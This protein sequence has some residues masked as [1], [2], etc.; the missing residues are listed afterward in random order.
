MENKLIQFGA[1]NIGRSFIGQ[2]FARNGYE[3]V[4]IDIDDTV[5]EEM[6]RRHNYRL[7]IKRNETE[8]ETVLVENVRAVHGS[9]FEAVASEIS[10]AAYIGSSVGQTAL[11]HIIPVIAKGLE[12]RRK[13][14]EVMDCID[15]II[16]ENIRNGAEFFR[17]GLKTH[18]PAEF[19]L[20]EKVGFVETS[21]G[22][23]VPIMRKEDR[24]IDP[25]WVFAEEY[26][27]LIVD[28]KGF[29]SS[30]PDLPGLKPVDNI[31]AYVDRKLFIHNLGHA[32]AAYFGFRKDPETVF[33]HE[34]LEDA[35]TRAKVRSAMQEAAAAL[36]REY[37]RDLP[38]EELEEHIDDLIRRFRNR[39]L[40]DTVFRV[41][42]DLQRKLGKDD[43]LV[44]AMITAEKHGTGYSSIAE[45]YNAAL[46]FR[47]GDENGKMFPGDREFADTIIPKGRGHIVEHVSG[48][49]RRDPVEKRVMETIQTVQNS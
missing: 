35:E 31:K 24:E 16:A 41:G 14:S 44:G 13:D 38:M 25:I 48:L 17:E 20:S 40:G 9:K 21:I 26:N 15:I 28:R 30:I 12:K 34:V 27:T 45:A 22:K 1:G 11:P 10:G 29:T 43:R 18:L 7:I 32:S 4:F 46:L 23:M 8:D 42:R 47:A 49:S 36:H 19:P 3:V 5:V 33:I 2:L 39:A 37:P 6:N